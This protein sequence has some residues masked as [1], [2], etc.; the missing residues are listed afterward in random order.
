MNKKRKKETT[1]E[2]SVQEQLSNDVTKYKLCNNNLVFRPNLKISYPIAESI[3]D[4][5]IKNNI[6]YAEACEALEIANDG[7]K[8]FKLIR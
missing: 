8:T 1:Q 2:V 6:T 7:I 5:I 3:I 4:I